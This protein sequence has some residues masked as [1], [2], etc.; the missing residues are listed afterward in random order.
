ML[1]T[2]GAM[3]RRLAVA[4][5]CST[6]V[7]ALWARTAF[8]AF[9]GRPGPIAYSKTL[10]RELGGGE[11]FEDGGIYARRAA[12]GQ[13]PRQVTL[14]VRD[15]EPSYSANGRRLVY[16]SFS[17][18][19][20]IFNGIY[21]VTFRGR[22]K[23]ETGALGSGPAFF[24]NGRRILFAHKDEGGHSHIYAARANG[25]RIRQLTSGPHNDSEP[26]ISPNGRRIA[27]V[28]DRGG[29]SDIF[30]MRAN[31][32]GI[33]PLVNAAG[34]ESAPDYSPR[35]NR[36]AFASTR[37]RGLSNVFVARA[38]GRAVW[39]L[40]RCES[41]SGCPAFSDPAFSPG[42]R[43]IAVLRST[44]RSTAVVVI[45]SDRSRPPIATIDSG[46]VDEEGSGVVI[47]APT[48]GPR[49]R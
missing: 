29:G 28:S 36:I 18:R 31:G 8:A 15:G 32:T 34:R 11:P 47:G 45:R 33:R 20:P 21:H 22:Q 35:G 23:R 24:P 5:F 30:T 14:S 40:T 13:R 48:W 3:T 9:P 43:R 42:G 10:I 37:G 1:T 2:K 17:E 39:W 25:A 41:L 44:A 38:D 49:P 19:S 12:R 16:T 46:S 6:I 27:F 4:L 26:A 7:L